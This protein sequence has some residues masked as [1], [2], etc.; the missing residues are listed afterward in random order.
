MTTNTTVV[1]ATKLGGW[2]VQML[3]IEEAA[4]KLK[5]ELGTGRPEIDGFIF[6]IGLAKDYLVVYWRDKAAMKRCKL[7][8]VYEGFRVESRYIGKMEIKRS[9]D[10]GI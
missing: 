1:I 4:D 7:P 2:R 6:N 3:N 5:L 8:E 9:K 10:G